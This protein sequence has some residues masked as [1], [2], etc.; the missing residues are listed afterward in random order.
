V[1]GRAGDRESERERERGREGVRAV[2]ETHTQ[3]TTNRRRRRKT[4]GT[5]PIFISHMTHP[6]QIENQVQEREY[7]PPT[8]PLHIYGRKIILSLK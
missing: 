3:S 1:N 5:N 2:E 8:P 6:T 7:I 4:G